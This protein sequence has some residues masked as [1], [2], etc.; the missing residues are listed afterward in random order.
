MRGREKAVCSRRGRGRGREKEA[1][2]R[3]GKGE[4]SML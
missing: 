1:C 3:R 4:G 2:F